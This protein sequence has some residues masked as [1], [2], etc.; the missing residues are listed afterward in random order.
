MRPGRYLKRIKLVK[1]RTMRS[2][3][4]DDGKPLSDEART[5][6]IGHLIRRSKLDELPQ[7][8][9]IIRGDMSFIGP[10][11]LLPRDQPG[12]AELRAIVR[13]GVTGWAQVNGGHPLEIEEKLALDIWYI[14]N[15][16]LWLDMK[17]LWLT[18]RT[19]LFGEKV[20]RAAI[21]MAIATREELRPAVRQ[22]HV[23]AAGQATIENAPAKTGDARPDPS[24]WPRPADSLDRAS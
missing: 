8:L 21:D 19:V 24:W 5:S 7:L 6:A 15:A 17:V 22:L 10:R 14:Q 9:S 4:G 23:A 11:P 16:S 2:G 12:D 20:N 1:F 3:L 18:L 13:P